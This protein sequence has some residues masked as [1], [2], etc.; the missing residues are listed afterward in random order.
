MVL[1]LGIGMST[2]LLINALRLLPV[3]SLCVCTVHFSLCE[4]RNIDVLPPGKGCPLAGQVSPQ[5]SYVITGGTSSIGLDL[6]LR[7]ARAGAGG[8]VLLSRFVAIR[9]TTSPLAIPGRSP[10]TGAS[11][12]ITALA[13]P[14]RYILNPPSFG[15]VTR[16]WL[17]LVFGVGGFVN[18][19]MSSAN[20]ETAN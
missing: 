6:A 20:V 12:E 1:L 17:Q 15:M 19:R 3:T 5:A 4:F 7:L 14:P 13:L 2:L 18:G 9:S 8:L 10:F 11:K 16:R